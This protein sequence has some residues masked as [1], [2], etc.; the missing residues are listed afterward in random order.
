MWCDNCL[1]VF[2]LRGGGIAWGVFV[3][4]YSLGGSLFL[5]MR[6]QFLFFVYPEW[7]I[8]GGIGMAVAAAALINVLALSNRSYIWS[9]VCHFLWPLVIVICG[10]R[11]IFL[12][13]ELNR[14]QDKIVWECENGGQLWGSTPE[15]AQ[16]LGNGVSFPSGICGPGFHTLFT[17]FIVS[18]LVD[19]VC[20]MYMWFLNWRFFKRLEHYKP[21]A[22]YPG[23]YPA[24]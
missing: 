10:V 6:G 22:A 4:A 24:L 20:Q 23:G 14:G 19:L 21:V 5:L 13:W 2:P 16:T 15:D 11:G 17:A 9:R 8:Y 12:L 3:A 1:L 7:F 18:I